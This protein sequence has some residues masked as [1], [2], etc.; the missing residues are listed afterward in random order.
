VFY[1]GSG[2]GWKGLV[3]LDKKT[4]KRLAKEFSNPQFETLDDFLDDPVIKHAI[5]LMTDLQQSDWSLLIDEMKLRPEE[6]QKVFIEKMNQ[7]IQSLPQ[8]KAMKKRM[9]KRK[10]QGLKDLWAF[11]FS[12][13]EAKN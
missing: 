8:V 7:L 4:A 11:L 13:T 1:V 3:V 12:R 9:T 2:L 5:S 10:I 6:E